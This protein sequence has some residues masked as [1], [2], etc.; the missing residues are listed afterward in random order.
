M[1]IDKH[2]RVEKLKKMI[3]SLCITVIEITNID[4]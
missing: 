2:K 4:F 1:K 3:I